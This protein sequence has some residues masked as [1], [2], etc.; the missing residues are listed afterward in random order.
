MIV[1][2]YF[3]EIDVK[4]MVM[5]TLEKRGSPEQGGHFGNVLF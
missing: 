5:S 2:G 1:L 3:N 4:A